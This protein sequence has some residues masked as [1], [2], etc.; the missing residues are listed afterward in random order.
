M[1]KSTLYAPKH[2]ILNAKLY[3]GE[4]ILELVTFFDFPAKDMKL[5]THFQGD[6]KYL[7]VKIPNKDIKINVGDYVCKTEYCNEDYAKYFTVPKSV[8]EMLYFKSK[9]EPTP[10]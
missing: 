9:S 10:F 2:P 4:N 6:Y 7:V 1:I 8:F 3:D 5:T